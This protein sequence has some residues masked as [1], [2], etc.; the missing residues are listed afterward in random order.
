MS[1]RDAQP[2]LIRHRCPKAP[3]RGRIDTRAA[4]S[5]RIETRCP[6]CGEVVV[7]QVPEALPADRTV[8]RCAL[9]PSEAFFIR[10]D[11]PQ[12]LGLALVILFALVASVF[13][14]RENIPATFGIL[15]AAVVVNLAIY[16]FT[17]RVTVCYRCRAE[18]RRVAYNPDHEEFDLATAEKHKNREPVS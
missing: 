2:I 5:G 12:R 4:R 3:C 18:Y 10:R 7:L 6:V 16:P 15:A 8:T 11:F 9:C 1:N 13:Y 14:Y 17:G